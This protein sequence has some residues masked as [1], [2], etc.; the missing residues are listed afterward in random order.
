MSEACAVAL[1]GAGYTAKEHAKAFAAVPGVRLAGIFSRTRARAVALAAERGIPEICGSVDELYE[2]TKA[3]LVV[4]TVNETSMLEIGLACFRHP[5]TVLF[6]KP[7]GLDLKES[8][9]LQAAAAKAGRRALVAHNRAFYSATTTAAAE[10]AA[11]EGPRFV[12]VQD[13]QNMDRVLAAGVPKPIA[14]N[15]MYANSL[16][17]IDYFRLFARGKAVRVERLSKYDP[18]RPEFVLARVEYDSG[19]QGLYE[20]VWRAPGPWSC[21]V[22][23]GAKRWEMRPLEQLTRQELGSPAAAVEIHSRDKDFKPGFLAQAEAA[24]AAALGRPSAST[25]L[26][27]SVETMRLI[28][29]IYDPS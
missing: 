4:V 18:A 22:A 11:T 9:A 10:L 21:A 27:Q 3:A 12:R 16:H 15:W 24:V 26:D 6:E 23:A 25:T 29:A 1:I 19:D 5:W 7:A 13:Q 8:L 17:L 20:A 28:A 14:D 2:K